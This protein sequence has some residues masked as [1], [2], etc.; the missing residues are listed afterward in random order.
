M[1]YRMVPM[2]THY[3]RG[4]VPGITTA[5]L[6]KQVYGP[7]DRG[8]KERVIASLH[9]L[10]EWVAKC[11]Q[12]NLLIVDEPLKVSEL[13]A[14][15]AREQMTWGPFDL[16]V[17]DHIGMMVPEGKVQSQ[18]QRMNEISGDL[19]KLS[20]SSLLGNPTLVFVSPFTKGEPTDLPGMHRF[21]DT[22]MLAHNAH[23]LLGIYEDETGNK[24]LHIAEMRSSNGQGD[25]SR[26]LPI[27]I[28]A[29]D[30]VIGEAA[31]ENHQL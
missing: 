18:T 22:F 4:L 11:C 16:V 15:L 13:R 29:E 3:L 17:A 7:I 10:L 25:V 8:V 23:L 21:R 1:G 27:G 28:S 2:V 19:L 26:D 20:K 30:G 14:L 24:L 12:G 31:A 5:D 6:L 9:R